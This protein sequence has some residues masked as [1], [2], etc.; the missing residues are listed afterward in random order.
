MRRHPS[1]NWASNLLALS[2]AA[3]WAMFVPFAQSSDHFF[4][5]FFCALA[6]HRRDGAR[7]TLAR[8]RLG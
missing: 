8:I 6:T 7:W 3:A 4:M 2:D 1:N 5:C